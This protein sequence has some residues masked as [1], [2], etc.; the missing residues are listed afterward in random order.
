[1]N[2]FYDALPRPLRLVCYLAGFLICIL[3]F[4]VLGWTGVLEIL[5]EADLEV[6]SESL[7]IPV[8]LYTSCTPLLSLLTIFRILQRGAEVLRLRKY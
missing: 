3:F 8:W 4:A 2:L 6:T 1:M 5:D 7:A